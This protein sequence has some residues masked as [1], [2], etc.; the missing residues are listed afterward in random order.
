MV[1][2]GSTGIDLAQREVPAI[3]F[4]LIHWCQTGE[5]ELEPMRLL[6]I[7]YLCNLEYPFMQRPPVISRV[8]LSAWRPHQ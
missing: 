3:V 6:A 2:L 5:L 8:L 7:T 4:H 1:K